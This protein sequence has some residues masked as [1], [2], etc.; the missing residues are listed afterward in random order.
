MPGAHEVLE[1]VAV[2][3][4][5][6]DDEAGDRAC[7]RADQLARRAPGVGEHVSG[8]TR[9]S[10]GSLAKIAS[11]G[12]VYW[13]WTSAQLGQNATSRGYRGSGSSARSGRHRHR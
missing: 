7:S 6:L 12:T 11:G 10:R 1:Q 5:E 4:G 2:V 3:A 9:R 8:R 13:S